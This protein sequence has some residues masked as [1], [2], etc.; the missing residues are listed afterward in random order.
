M[1]ASDTEAVI[2]ITSGLLRIGVAVLEDLAR[3][4]PAPA[5]PIFGEVRQHLADLSVELARRPESVLAAAEDGQLESLLVQFGPGDPFESS[6]YLS[7]ADLRPGDLVVR[8]A[9]ALS[10]QLTELMIWSRYT[11]SGL[12]VGNGE[13]I[14]STWQYGVR[15]RRLAELLDESNRVGVLRLPGLSADQARRVQAV[16]ESKEP[17]DYNFAGVATLG[18]QKLAELTKAPP[19]TVGHLLDILGKAESLPPAVTGT[20]SFA[21][22]ELVAFAFDSANITLSSASGFTPGDMMRLSQAGLLRQI[23]RLPLPA[24]RDAASG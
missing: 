9:P 4:L 24:T 13:I 14:D 1:V 10:S 23:G 8:C 15:R 19:Q 22:S 12:Y 11:H 17:A 5:A 2:E 7:A 20:G 16:A 6:P 3:L 18:A 21:C